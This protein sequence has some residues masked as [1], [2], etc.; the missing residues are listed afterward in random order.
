MN[1]LQ[2]GLPPSRDASGAES[3]CPA[4]DAVTPEEGSVGALPLVARDA[5]ELATSSR[6][7]GVAVS[8]ENDEVSRPEQTVRPLNYAWEQTDDE[9][10]IY[11]EFDQSDELSAGVSEEA[12]SVEFAEWNLLLIIKSSCEGKSPL[13]L[14][15]GDFQH[16]VDPERCKVAVR[17]KRITLR[18]RKLV[19]EY[20]FNLVQ[21]KCNH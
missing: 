20:W 15:L 13:G 2:P 14:R 12:V 6:F 9:I 17:S 21:R 1:D 7:S 4:S 10:K 11:V 5:D 19:S 8:S 18:L 3:A 16:R